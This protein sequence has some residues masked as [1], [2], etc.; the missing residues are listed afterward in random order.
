MQ[1]ENP[2]VEMAAA[3]AVDVFRE[4]VG[5]KVTPK[6]SGEGIGVGGEFGRLTRKESIYLRDGSPCVA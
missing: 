4:P 1:P 6:V 5:L 2:H 3:D